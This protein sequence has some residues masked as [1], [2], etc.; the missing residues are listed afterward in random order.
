MILLHKTDPFLAKKHNEYLE[1]MRKKRK[2]AKA[3]T[4]YERM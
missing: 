2:E 1:Y 4:F 3:Q